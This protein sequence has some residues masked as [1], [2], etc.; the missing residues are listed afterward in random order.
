MGPSNNNAC[1]VK[2]LI[3]NKNKD[4]DLRIQVYKLGGKAVYFTKVVMA[5]VLFGMAAYM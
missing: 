2:F 4:H 3:T 5:S 1:L